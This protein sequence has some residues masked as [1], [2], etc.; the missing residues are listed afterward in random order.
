MGRRGRAGR[1]HAAAVV[2]VAV[3]MAAPCTGALAGDLRILAHD[4]GFAIEVG[5]QAAV[6]AIDD[7]FRILPEGQAMVRSPPMVEIR[8]LDADTPLP[9]LDDTRTIAGVPIAYGVETVTE[10]SGGTEYTLTARRDLCGGILQLTQWEQ[11]EFGG[12]PDFE[13]G[14]GLLMSATCTSAADEGQGQ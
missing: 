11:H 9:P 8:L 13:A 3:F 10:G 6:E 4:R 14:W 1:G 12:T 5:D 2:L 7:G